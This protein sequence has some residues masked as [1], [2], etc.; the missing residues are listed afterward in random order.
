MF[1]PTGTPT[2]RF[3]ATIGVLIAIVGGLWFNQDRG[4]KAVATTTHDALCALR[5][6]IQQ[7]H[8]DGAKYLKSHPRGLI[9]N[10]GKALISAAQIRDSLRN[11][12]ST[13]DALEP[14]KC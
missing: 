10:S 6:D 4:L 13:L 9:G 1:S 12:E 2:R 11:Q 3:V 5:A 8:D 7:R 14:L